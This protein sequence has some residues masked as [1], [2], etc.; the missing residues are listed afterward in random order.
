MT[1]QLSSV[2]HSSL[3]S[4]FVF[5]LTCLFLKF[6]Y[7]SE[8]LHSKHGWMHLKDLNYIRLVELLDCSVCPCNCICFFVCVMNR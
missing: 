4:L 5:G 3:L 2:A 7:L 8:S 1:Y 6:L